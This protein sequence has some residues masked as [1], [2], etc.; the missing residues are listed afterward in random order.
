M[1]LPDA[2]SRY[3]D[4]TSLSKAL[5][6]CSHEQ[7]MAWVYRLDEPEQR[8]LYDLALGQNLS[9]DDLTAGEKQV[10]VHAGRNGLALFNRFEKHIAL[11]GDEVVGY[12]NNDDIAGPFSFLLKRLIGP[13]HFIAYNGP[14]SDVW[15]DY[16]RI[17]TRRHPA[18][19]PLIDND[20][21][22]RA[23]VFGN[24]VDKL[25]RVSTHVCI[26][27]SLKNLSRP[28]TLMSRIGSKFPT[29]TFVVVRRP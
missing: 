18:F 25:R 22:T 27:D 19:P 24:M 28:R 29:A 21:G 23:L 26:G 15:I 16:R 12:N 4:L 9:V 6:A 14:D 7:R 10:V 2:P 1:A 3:E 13:G 8:V 11:L 5:D 20:H 17:P